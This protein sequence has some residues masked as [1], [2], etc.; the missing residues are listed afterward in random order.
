MQPLISVIIPA[1]NCE[2]YIAKALD[3]V[4]NQ[5]YENLEV[6][7]V[8]DCSKDTTLNIVQCYQNIDSRVHILKH[9]NNRGV[10]CTR[11]F[12]VKEAK[13]DWIALLDSDDYWKLDKL[14]K[15]MKRIQETDSFMCCTG[16]KLINKEGKEIG[17]NIP[18]LEFVTYKMLLRT[19]YIVCS[20]IL[21]K[22]SL[23][24]EF[25]MN[26]DELHE[27]YVCWLQ[28]TQKY[29]AIV[30]IN[31]PLVSYRV[32]KNSK[33]GNKWKSFI[34]QKRSY[35]LIGI[36]FWAKWVY[37]VLYSFNGFWKYHGV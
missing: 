24:L 33:S 37:L 18:V 17:R 6:I 14:E 15:Q 8:D 25:P 4:L 10:S 23:L 34:M 36:S 1:Y 32:I 22:K 35:Q 30:G 5:S 3:S 12:G 21:I 19:N 26:N 13:G 29:G 7:V 20:S 27:D 11:N 28:I 31:E 16:R 9:K 2:K